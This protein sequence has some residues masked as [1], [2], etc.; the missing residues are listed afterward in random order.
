MVV[1]WTEPLEWACIL[2]AAQACCEQGAEYASEDGCCEQRVP[3]TL[4]QDAL[5]HK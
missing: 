5:W 1:F 4:V 3:S 2:T